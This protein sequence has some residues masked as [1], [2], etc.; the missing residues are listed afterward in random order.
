MNSII[1]GFSLILFAG[2]SGGLVGLPLRLRRRYAIE[3]M[4]LLGYLVGVIIIPLFAAQLLLPHWQ[5]AV[6]NAGIKPVLIAAAFGIGWGIASVA[7]ALGI[8]T[9]GLSL[10]YAVI[11]GINMVAGSLIPLI[12]RWQGIS[13]E[14]RIFIFLGIIL[15]VVGVTICG[16][17]GIM[18]E[19]SVAER[20]SVGRLLAGIVWCIL[21]GLLSACINVGFDFAERIS[22]ETIKLGAHP[23]YSSIGRWLPIYWGGYAAVL[24]IFGTRMLKHR[25]WTNFFGPGS[26]R[27]FILTLVM[28]VLLV[29][30]PIQYGMAVCYLGQ[31]GTSVGWGILIILIIIVANIVGFFTGE[32]KNAS[33]SSVITFYTGLAILVLAILCFC[34]SFMK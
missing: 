23:V 32:W 9:V 2:I 6:A 14:A 7:F 27:D 13:E 11:M 18:R 31:L 22:E 4:C 26:G 5:L 1:A 29:L 30:S 24:V 21:S 12:R 3:N 20:T 16:K 17:A 33:K 25:I 10:G 19:S 34:N 28:A 8:S 15:S